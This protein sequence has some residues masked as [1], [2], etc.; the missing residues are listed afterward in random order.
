M[1]NGEGGGGGGVETII[2]SLMLVYL[3]VLDR[4]LARFSPPPIRSIQDVSCSI[5]ALNRNLPGGGGGEV[6]GAGGLGVVG[7]EVKTVGPSVAF[8]S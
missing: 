8:Q 1:E 3:L 7:R 6:V 4:S 5:P 2:N